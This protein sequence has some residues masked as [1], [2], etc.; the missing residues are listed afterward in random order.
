M[1]R[2]SAILALS[3]LAS[4]GTLAWS[5]PSRAQSAEADSEEDDSW[6]SRRPRLRD[7]LT[8]GMSLGG[9]AAGVSGY[10][11]DPKFQNDPN[12]YSAS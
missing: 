4:L 9:G 8:L 12:Q 2:T 7:G 10:P 5:R 1:K 11:N 3:L 6:K